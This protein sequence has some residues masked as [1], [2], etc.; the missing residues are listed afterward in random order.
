MN[1]EKPKGTVYLLHFDRP[2]RHA[3]HYT[4]WTADLD[5]R[6]AEH[7][8]GRGARLMAVIRNAG[9]GFQLARTWDG[10]RG[11][12]RQLKREGGASRRC[13]MCGVTPRRESDP[14]DLRAV[15]LRA[16][17]DI[18][19]RHADRPRTGQWGPPLPNWARSLPAAELD[20]RLDQVEAAWTDK[21]SD[22]RRTR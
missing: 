19:A 1:R 4:G 11:R 20:R 21:S 16:R 7:R 6:L 3:R 22:R 5:A 17:R 10:T 18:A 2:Y 9:I 13:P 12:E 14:E 8:D 15:V